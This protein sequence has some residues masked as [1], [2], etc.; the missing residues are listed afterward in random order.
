MTDMREQ[1]AKS[2]SENGLALIVQEHFPK[3]GG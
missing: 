3:D 1:D 2:E